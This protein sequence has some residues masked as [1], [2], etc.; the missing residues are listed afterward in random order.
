MT[1]ARRVFTGA[2]IYGL[3]VLLPLY[4]AEGRI[5]Q[6]Q[7][8]PINHPEYYYGFVGCAVAFQ[9]VFLTIGRDPLKY[10]PFMLPSIVEKLTYGGAVLVLLAQ[11]R[12]PTPPLIG[13]LIDLFLG[14]LFL[15]AYVKTS[16]R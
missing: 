16:A 2:G 9:L 4:F 11:S 10:R 15:V 13:G 7:P 3:I 6:D 5:A 14:V 12:I 1:F 8:P